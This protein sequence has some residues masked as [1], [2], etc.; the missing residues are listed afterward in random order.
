MSKDKIP[1]LTRLITLCSSPLKIVNLDDYTQ[2]VREWAR[3]TT[4]TYLLHL[5]MVEVS[6]GQSTEL[7][8]F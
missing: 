2:R 1:D 7:N 5:L 8:H 4:L 3:Q 6:A